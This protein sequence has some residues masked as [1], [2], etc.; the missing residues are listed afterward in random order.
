[1]PIQILCDRDNTPVPPF[2]T[3][4]EC[5]CAFPQSNDTEEGIWLTVYTL[6]E[7]DGT[8]VADLLQKQGFRVID[9]QAQGV[10][11]VH[12]AYHRIQIPTEEAKYLARWVGKPTNVVNFH[13]HY[14][15][16][17]DINLPDAQVDALF[18]QAKIALG[19]LLYFYDPNR[20]PGQRFW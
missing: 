11:D 5:I 18:N 3:R 20:A 15:L 13:K 1:M 4:I 19:P 7:E 2:N 16:T 17:D 14:M 8:L 6:H 12:N 10:G 9:D